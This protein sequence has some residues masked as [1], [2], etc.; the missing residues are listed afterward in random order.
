M[1]EE[2]WH[3]VRNTHALLESTS[4]I[5][6]VAK[7]AGWISLE[8]L[9]MQ[10]GDNFMLLNRSYYYENWDLDYPIYHSTSTYKICS[11]LA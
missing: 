5:T 8:V 10:F 1:L 9:I 2:D 7:H 6:L 3:A 4:V 11:H